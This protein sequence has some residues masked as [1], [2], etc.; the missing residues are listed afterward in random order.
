MGSMMDCCDKCSL[1]AHVVRALKLRGEDFYFGIWCCR[2]SSFFLYLKYLFFKV[3]RKIKMLI[4]PNVLFYPK[5]VFFCW[6]SIVLSGSLLRSR[7]QMISCHSYGFTCADLEVLVHGQGHK[8]VSG[9]PDTWSVSNDD[10]ESLV[11]LHRWNWLIQNESSLGFVEKDKAFGLLNSYL[12]MFGPL[13]TGVVSEP[14]TIAERI[15]NLVLYNKAAG[16]G[17]SLPFS[18]LQLAL[19]G[20]ASR[21]KNELE[22]GGGETCTGNHAFNNGRALYIFGLVSGSPGYARLGSEI[23]YHQLPGLL[24]QDGFLREG[25][26]H[27][28][29]IF[30][31]WMLEICLV[32]FEF[33]DH[34][35]LHFIECYV[36]NALSK[37][38]FFFVRKTYDGPLRQFVLS[39]DIS[40]DCPPCWLTGI[41]ETKIARSFYHSELCS[42]KNTERVAGW[43]EFID[44]CSHIELRMNASAKA[45]VGVFETFPRSGWHRVDWNGWEAFWRSDPERVGDFPSHCHQDFAAPVVFKDGYPVL[46]ATGRISYV[47]DECSNYGQSAHSHSTVFVNGIPPSL[48][49]RDVKY[50]PGYRATESTFSAHFDDVENLYIKVCHD[51]FKRLTEP[52]SHSRV[53]VFSR[54]ELVVSDYFDGQ[55]WQ[56][57][58]IRFHSPDDH[59]SVTLG[60]YDDNLLK[61]VDKCVFRGSQDR[62]EGWASTQYGEKFP[63][64]TYVMRCQ[65]FLP[66]KIEH[67]IS[68]LKQPRESVCVE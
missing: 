39:G 34:D 10:R 1:G 11:Y 35:M 23:V 15:V 44:S 37:C 40:P 9:N 42:D 41:L 53:F 33:D 13:P 2:P 4:L 29:L 46:M 65:V 43:R 19:R 12:R 30:T 50:P 58:E 68:I 20:M 14:Y 24:T 26:S 47:S 21:L 6:F 48:T 8:I 52:V 45:A 38:E 28:H 56:S 60:D 62:C 27:Y 3:S 32:A 64:N 22:F 31:R 59:V 17:W 7:D 63:C 67:R 25:S 51:G 55:G 57:V 61:V 36:A 5:Q 49:V 54:E 18:S 66:S 16:N